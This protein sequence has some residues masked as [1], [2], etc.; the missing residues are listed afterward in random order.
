MSNRS[1]SRTFNGNLSTQ[2][3]AKN[4]KLCLSYDALHRRTQKNFGTTTVA[5]GTNT[6]VYSAEP[7]PP[8]PTPMI[9]SAI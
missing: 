2:V 4:Q 9:R 1:A 8:S 7:M 6:I 3:D 5:C